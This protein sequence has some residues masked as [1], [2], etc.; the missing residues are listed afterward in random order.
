MVNGLLESGHRLKK[1]CHCCVCDTASTLKDLNLENVV[2]NLGLIPGYTFVEI[3]FFM[4]MFVAIRE[5][6]E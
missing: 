5:K 1:I 4:L 2:D 6:V 3:S